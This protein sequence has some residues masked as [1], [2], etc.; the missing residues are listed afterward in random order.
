MIN[1]EIVNSLNDL[2]LNI[3]SV[4]KNKWNGFLH[5]I[6]YCTN[7]NLYISFVHA[8]RTTCVL[9]SIVIDKKKVIFQT[10]PILMLL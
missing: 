5:N 2:K 8:T 7:I 3:S 10:L 6:I 1:K 9:M 4:D